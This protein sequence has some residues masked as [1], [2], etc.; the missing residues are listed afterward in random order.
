MNISLVSSTGGHWSQLNV[1]YK[2]FQ[3]N[4]I[5]SINIETI[6]ERND[7]NKNN[8]NLRFLFQQDRKNKFFIFILL[9]NLIKSFYYVLSFKPDYVISTGAGVTI[10]YLLFAKLFGA[11]IIYMESFAKVNSPTLTGRFVYRFADFFYVQWPELLKFY[12]KGI[13]KGSLY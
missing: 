7:S 8:K 10:F 13:Y 2:E 6:T 12:P 3:K 5:D 9:L 4:N 11:K 1:I